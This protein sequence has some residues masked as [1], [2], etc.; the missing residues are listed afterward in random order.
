MNG[1]IIS[2]I[3]TPGL[4]FDCANRHCPEGIYHQ[5]DDIWLYLPEGNTVSISAEWY[6]GKCYPSTIKKKISLLSWI[7]ADPQKFIKDFL[8]DCQKDCTPNAR[9]G[10]ETT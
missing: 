10:I 2:M 6:C 1:E 8:D 3:E 7:E 4:W 5:A 9:K